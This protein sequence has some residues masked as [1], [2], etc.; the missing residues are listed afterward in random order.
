MNNDNNVI[1]ESEMWHDDDML[2]GIDTQSFQ[3]G[4]TD[5]KNNTNN[6]NIKSNKL[7]DSK[8]VAETPAVLLSTNE[9]S[10]NQKCEGFKYASK[11]PITISKK[12]LEQAKVF[13]KKIMNE[14]LSLAE[15]KENIALISNQ[16][17]PEQVKSQ[18][19]DQINVNE[20]LNDSL[21]DQIDFDEE[22]HEFEP[23]LPGL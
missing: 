1:T 16:K 11:K 12:A 20:L 19:N 22:C 5:L 18:N 10:A 6:R 9:N 7:I 21:L 4:I 3:I 2:Q 17:L 13:M 15:D 8:L 23:I 14:D